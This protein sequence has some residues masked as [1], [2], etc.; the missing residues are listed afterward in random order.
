MAVRRDIADFFRRLQLRRALAGPQV[1]AFLPAVTLTAY[2]LWGEV[3]LLSAAFGL[4][5]IYAAFGTF[6][7]RRPNQMSAHEAISDDG[8]RSRLIQTMDN[9]FSDEGGDGRNAICVVIE[10]DEFKSIEERFGH[11]IGQDVL[12]RTAERIAACLREFD[13]LARITPTT[14]A[15]AVAP[16]R[17]CD[18]EVA[19]QIAGRL[20][21]AVEKPFA[22]DG[23]SVYVSS[24][25]GFCLTNRAPIKSGEALMDAS[26]VA[27][28]EARRN[29]PSAIRSYTPEM[30]SRIDARHS[31]IEDVGTALDNNDIVPWFQP[32]ISTETGKITGFEALA[33]WH[34]PERGLVSPA[35]F[36]PA[37]EQ[38]G[39]ME[40]LGEKMIFQ[41]LTALKSWDAAGVTVPTV[42]VNFSPDELRNP[43][44]VDKIRWELDRFE[45]NPDRLAVEVLE[46]VVATSADDTITLNIG[47]L[48]ALGC[49]IDL[50]DFGTGHASISSIRRFS[51]NRIKIDR[52]FVTKVDVDTEQ[53]R[54]L[55]A[56]LLMAERLNLDTLAEG[57]ETVGEHTIIA[58]LGCGHVQGYGLAR[59]MPFEET[60]DWIERH[61]ATLGQTPQITRGA[62]G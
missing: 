43:K 33:R 7:T 53:Q 41:A 8:L 17:R 20:Q 34:H 14:F 5:A 35:E 25:I 51:V 59:P 3:G 48:A 16:M 55:A 12:I 39:L 27:M 42:G 28:I 46:S 58:Q 49:L 6:G 40:R 62:R 37:V 11:K 18:L 36:L 19:I 31:L 45:L 60:L 38:A 15:I 22:V 32:Q 13:Q 54:M 4:P 57:V 61:V 21:D 44:L 10:V 1:L 9:Y 2:W 50:D 29:G 56:I 23:L 52:S 47:G 26:M 24:N 30:R